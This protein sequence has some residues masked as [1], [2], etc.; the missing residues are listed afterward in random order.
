L[1]SEFGKPHQ[2][3]LNDGRNIDPDISYLTGEGASQ[4][5]HISRHPG[6][7][8]KAL[9]N[10][11]PEVSRQDPTYYGMPMLKKPV[12]EWAIPL[13]YYVG[14]LSGA[15]I[16]LGAAT[17]LFGNREAQRAARTCRWMGMCGASLG[18]ALLVYDL[19]RSSRFLNMLRVFR[20]TSPMN[21]GAWI[22]A[23]TVP[24][25]FA[26][27][28]LSSQRGFAGILGSTFG[29]ISGAFGM[30]LATYTGVL[31]SNSAIPVWSE[32]RTLLPILFGA[33]AMASAA[34]AFDVL[35]AEHEHRS[36]GAF[37]LLGRVGELGVA[38]MLE[39]RLLETPR[40]SRPLHEGKSGFLWK[41]ATVL[42]AG[43]LL[44][45]LLPI[46]KRRK[47]ILAGVLASLGSVCLR[48]GIHEAG[49]PSAKDSR[50][51]FRLQ[52]HQLDQRGRN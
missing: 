9:W 1:S 23:G 24:S 16:A 44:V 45:N 22:L 7:E 11:M 37:G 43:S 15:S 17:Q 47:R 10:R 38:Q 18:G 32:S 28:V 14:G 52:H 6:P 8:S 48:F 5:I 40:V 50:A 2:P 31:V 27:E 13:Y 20:P 51:S 29:L 41:A 19:G 35:H 3:A 33:S 36:V 26:A 4:A 34:A 21:V 49:V 42:T 30:G 12:W 46:Q 25:A 39:R